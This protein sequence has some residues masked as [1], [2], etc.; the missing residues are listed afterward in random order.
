VLHAP[1][2]L[3]PRQRL[4]LARLVVEE[5]WPKSRAGELFGVSWRT[6]DRWAERYRVAGRAGMADAAAARTPA[7]RRPP[8]R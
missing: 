3:T 4:R 2:V 7:P 1:A 8:R 5:R 6:A